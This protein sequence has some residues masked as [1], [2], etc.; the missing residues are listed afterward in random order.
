MKT[1]T[2]NVVTLFVLQIRL[3]FLPQHCDH[4][5]VN[6][7]SLQFSSPWLI[8]WIPCKIHRKYFYSAALLVGKPHLSWSSNFE[9]PV[10]LDCLTEDIDDFW[11]CLLAHQQMTYDVKTQKNV[12]FARRRTEKVVT[13]LLVLAGKLLQLGVGTSVIE[14]C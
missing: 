1:S 7:L 12:G 14:E 10:F 3:N 2:P 4:R 13:V 8:W 11:D 9:H 6:Y 5:N